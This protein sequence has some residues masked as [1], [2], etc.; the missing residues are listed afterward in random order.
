[1]NAWSKKSNVLFQLAGREVGQVRIAREP[2]GHWSYLGTDLLLIQSDKP[3]LN[4]EGFSMSTPEAEFARVVRHLAGH[5][6]GFG[7]ESLPQEVI[8]R[9]DRPK[10]YAHFREAKGWDQHMEDETVLKPL[11]EHTSMFTS[12]STASIMSYQLPGEVMQNGRAFLGG[13]DILDSDHHFAE[14]VYPKSRYPY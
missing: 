8:A 6:L 7:H 4:L 1:M 2:G 5:A 13:Q 9:I 12:P 11:N 3:T 10:A 14:R